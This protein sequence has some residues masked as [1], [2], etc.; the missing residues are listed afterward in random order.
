MQQRGQMTGIEALV[1][2]GNLF[3]RPPPVPKVVLTFEVDALRGCYGRSSFFEADQ[4]HELVLQASLSSIGVR[5]IP[6]PR[7]F[8]HARWLD[9]D[10]RFLAQLSA[11]G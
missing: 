4:G 9:R 8:A 5:D 10:T 1:T 11:C 7:W 2:A 6:P 3:N